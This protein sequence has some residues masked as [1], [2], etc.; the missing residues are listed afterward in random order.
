MLYPGLFPSLEKV[1]RDMARDI[2]WHEFD[3]R[4]PRMA[5]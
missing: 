5:A 2:P 3:P 4:R 1:R